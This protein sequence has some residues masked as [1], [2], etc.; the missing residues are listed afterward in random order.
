MTAFEMKIKDI[1]TMDEVRI[2]LLN[3]ISL[4]TTIVKTGIRRKTGTAKEDK[5]SIGWGNF[6]TSENIN[7]YKIEK[8]TMLP[9]IC[10]QGT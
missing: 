1:L 4:S 8:S 10:G 5:I 2:Q 7:T 6:E 9:Y 3:F